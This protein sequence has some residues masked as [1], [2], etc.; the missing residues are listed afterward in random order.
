MNKFVIVGSAEDKRIELF[1]AALA[2]IGLPAATLVTYL[3]LIAGRATL[4]DQLAAGDVLRIE[5]PGKSAETNRLLLQLGQPFV[6]LQFAKVNPSTLPTEKG[7]IDSTR[8]W[9][10]GL[11][12]ALDQIDAQRA[13]SPTHRIM[14]G[15]GAI[16]TMFDKRATHAVLHAAGVP[17]PPAL[18][19]VQTYDELR[20]AMKI[21]RMA[22]VF[23]KP[24]HGSSASG[25][26]AYETS[27]SR[28][29][30]TTTVERGPN[31]NLF[32]TRCIRVIRDHAEII[33]LINVVCRQRVHV[34]RWLPKGSLQGQRFD[35][36]V[37]VIGGQAQHSIVRLSRTPFTNLHLLNDRAPIDTLIDQ[38]GA[39]A[40]VRAAA[41][42]ERADACFPNAF[43]SGVDL[44]FSADLRRQY[45]LELNAFGDL[46][47]TV[48]VNGVDT[49]E[50]EIRTFLN[51]CRES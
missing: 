15:T 18:P 26:I 29:Q 47:P 7:R 9:Y 33:D 50:M 13:V 22:R 45:V 30:A 48:C 24:A 28:Q 1:Q 42:C 10:L 4:Q 25:A 6:E 17:V 12:A 37:V 23:I 34:E 39:D 20:E 36:R 51:R 43:Y 35:V 3:D 21:G 49:Y 40:W 46:L 31:G 19:P 8:Q 27:G 44:L 2:R 38:I 41:I 16:R 11:C 14:T 5:S 32:N